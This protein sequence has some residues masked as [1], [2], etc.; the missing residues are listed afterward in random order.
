MAQGGTGS[1]YYH[2]TGNPGYSNTYTGFNQAYNGA[3]G[4]NQDRTVAYCYPLWIPSKLRACFK[5]F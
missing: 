3:M 2:T 4:S 5:Q 1:G